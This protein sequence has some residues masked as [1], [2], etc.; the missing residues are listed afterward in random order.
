MLKATPEN[1]QKMYFSG[2]RVQAEV[3]LLDGWVG[4]WWDCNSGDNIFLVSLQTHHRYL[5]FVEAFEKDK[6]LLVELR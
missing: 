4:E 3:Y 5:K 1:F 6:P 2:L